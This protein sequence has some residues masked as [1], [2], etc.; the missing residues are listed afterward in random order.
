MLSCEVVF[1]S[2][3][4]DRQTAVRDSWDASAIEDS[5]LTIASNP[6]ANIDRTPHKVCRNII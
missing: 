2:F 5:K 4:A 3:L 1:S 6:N